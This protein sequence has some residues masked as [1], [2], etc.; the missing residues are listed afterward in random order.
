MVLITLKK[1]ILFEKDLKVPAFD[2]VEKALKKLQPDL[3]VIATP[4]ETHNS[5][6]SKII[7]L[8]KPRIIL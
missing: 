5:I 6:L 2:N 3:V 1:K 8:S 7:N 4:T